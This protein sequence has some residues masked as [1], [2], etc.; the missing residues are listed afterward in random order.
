MYRFLGVTT[1]LCMVS[2]LAIAQSP[3]DEVTFNL[4]PN[5]TFLT[6]LSGSGQAPKATVVVKRGEL[7]D[8]ALIRVTGLKPNLQFDLFTVQRSPLDSGGAPVSG[9]KGFGL[10]WYQTDLNADE[11]G[12]AKVVIKTILLD[13]IFGFDGDAAPTQVASNTSTAPT[14]VLKPTNTFHMGF[15][16]NN[17][18]DA[19]PCGF[20]TSKPTPFNGEHKAGPLAMISLP[21][22]PQNLGPLCTSPTGASGVDDSGTDSTGTVFACNP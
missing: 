15:W 10:A 14:T 20:D 9:F 11:Q 13:Q 8:T 17:P 21:V 18:E 1:A 6:C 5:K 2:S 12:N 4:V 19:A 7:N 3:P 22:E 16:F